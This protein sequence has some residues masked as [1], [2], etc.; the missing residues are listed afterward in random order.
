M[1]FDSYGQLYLVSV[2]NH[3]ENHAHRCF[4]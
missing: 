3:D 1:L 4:G 2:W